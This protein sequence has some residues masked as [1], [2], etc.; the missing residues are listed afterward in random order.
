MCMLASVDWHS[1]FVPSISLLEIVLRGT[2]VYLSIFILLRVVLKR[3]SGNM[4]VSDLLVIVLIADAAQNAM[5]SEYKSVPEGLVLVATI[6]FWS[7]A[8]DWLNF[9]V[10]WVRRLISPPPLELIRDGKVNR[11]HLRQELI[12]IEEL[13]EQL[14][15]QGIED[16]ALVRQACM[17]SDGRISIVKND[18]EQHKQPKESMM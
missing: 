17:E 2:V 11:R 6:V 1:M 14:R 9:H 12:T 3:Q 8:L 16:I 10:S 13:K 18:E 15:E 5:A 7:Y 4:G